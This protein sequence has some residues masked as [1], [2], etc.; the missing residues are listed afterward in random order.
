VRGVTPIVRVPN[1]YPSTILRYLDTGAQGLHVPCVE[2]ASN[3]QTVIRSVKYYPLGTRGLAGVRAAAYGQE[4]LSEYVRSANAETLVALHIETAAAIERLPEILAVDGIDVIFV[5]PMDLSNSL[6]VPGEIEHAKVQAAI[7][8]IVG[9]VAKSA[10]ALGIV[11]GD[12]QSARAW[13]QRGARYIAIGFE[14]LIRTCS[15]D[16]LRLAHAESR[17]K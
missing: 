1:D 11:V 9:T 14:A 12:A 13:N 16:Y 6:G 17:T 3:A 5:G 15:R 8:R 4:P 7:D 10:T 2:S